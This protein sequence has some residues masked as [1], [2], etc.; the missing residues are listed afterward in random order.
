MKEW[1]FVHFASPKTNYDYS[2]FG[3]YAPAQ[4][5]RCDFCVRERGD[6]LTVGDVPREQSVTYFFFTFTHSSH[7]FRTKIDSRFCEGPHDGGSTYILGG[8]GRA[9]VPTRGNQRG[10]YTI[11]VI[12]LS[13]T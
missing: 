6:G 12:G 13:T 5:C 4:L 10:V 1:P 2:N 9:Y 3:S 8:G 7:R 11:I